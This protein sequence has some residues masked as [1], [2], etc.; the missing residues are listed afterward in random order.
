MR[1]FI[2]QEN[3]RRLQALLSH[4]TD[5]ARRG[6]L[7]ALLAEAENELAIGMDVWRHTSHLNIPRPVSQMLEDELE[8]FV[9]RQRAAYG[10]LQIY[11]GQERVLYLVAQLNFTASL[12]HN[13]GSIPVLDGGT[14]CARAAALGESIYVP[15]LRENGSDYPLTVAHASDKVRAVQSTPVFAKDGNLLGVFSSHYAESHDFNEEE[16]M[17]CAKTAL[18]LRPLMERALYA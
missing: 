18:R 17:S 10:S 14:V 5:D 4:A 3:V 1:R 16:R 15:D 6:Q 8:E 11:D 2:L 12:V 9:E 13:F 7:S